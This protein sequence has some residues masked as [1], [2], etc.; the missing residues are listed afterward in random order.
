MQGFCELCGKW[1]Y[2][3]H[4]HHIFFGH[5][6]RQISERY[7]ATAMLCPLCHSIDRKQGVHG[8]HWICLQ[9]QEQMQRKLMA[10]H[11]WT[12]EDF[13]RIFGKSYL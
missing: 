11:D 12:T 3:L 1:S 9:L 7:D 10:K 13:I 8:N 5:K 2:H 4:R 6:Q